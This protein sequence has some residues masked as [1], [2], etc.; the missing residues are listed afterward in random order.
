MKNIN[1]LTAD[2]LK[3]IDEGMDEATRDEMNDVFIEFGKNMEKMLRR[4]VTPYVRKSRNISF[5]ALGYGARRLYYQYNGAESE[6]FTPQTKVKFMLGNIV[7]EIMLSMAKLAGHTVEHSQA[8]IEYKGI[9]GYCDAVIDGVM[10]DVKSAASF[11]FKKIKEGLNDSND[12]FGY[13][14]QL[15]GYA[16]GGPQANKTDCALW[17]MDKQ[18][19][20]IAL[21]SFRVED[22]PNVDA[23]IKVV[24]DVYDQT[25]PPAFCY[26]LVPEGKAGN[27]KLPIGCAYCPFKKECYKD[28][29]GGKGL[30]TFLY[31][32][33]PTHFAHIEK[34]PN[35]QELTNG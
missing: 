16:I 5:S 4:Q 10:V 17:V 22:M 30:R 21:A 8:R 9:T 31:Y 15:A 11:S 24:N 2:V 18:L 33:G 28:S 23:K 27:M 35:V 6:K 13:R 14:M 12:L 1:T 29:N 19:G 3:V 20:H 34:T 32:N 26:D 7:E 25:T